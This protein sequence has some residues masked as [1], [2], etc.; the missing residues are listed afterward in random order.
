MC[1]EKVNTQ[2]C[3]LHVLTK[4]MKYSSDSGWDLYTSFISPKCRLETYIVPSFPRK[5]SG[6][7]R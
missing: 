7:I 2:F 3:F 5:Y 4:S 6:L 1:A